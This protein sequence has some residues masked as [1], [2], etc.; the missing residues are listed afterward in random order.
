MTLNPLSPSTN[1]AARGENQSIQNPIKTQASLRTMSQK[2]ITS[3]AVATIGITVAI[4]GSL[5]ADQSF[6]K[7][8]TWSTGGGY[9]SAK[10]TAQVYDEYTSGKNH[11]ILQK[12]NA[13]ATA[14]GRSKTLAN[15]DSSL[16]VDYKTG[17]GKLTGKLKIFSKTY[18]NI[19]K[20]FKTSTTH[21]TTPIT[22]KLPIANKRFTVGVVPVRV[23][24]DVS[25]TLSSKATLA[26][27]KDN[28]SL[29]P[30]VVARVEA[31]L[32]VAA[33]ASA[34]ADAWVAAVG[35]RGT[36]SLMKSNLKAYVKL[37][38]KAISTFNRNLLL[39]YGFDWKLSTMSGTLKAF[40]KVNYFCGSKT[41]TKTIASWKGVATTIKLASGAKTVGRVFQSGQNSPVQV[42]NTNVVKSTTTSVSRLASPFSFA[43]F[44]TAR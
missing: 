44:M 20:S 3:L 40:A 18:A 21:K 23:Y 38:S 37:H 7:S 12:A 28:G 5:H 25:L 33:S 42:G 32:D 24:A 9:F 22:K 27:T 8:R 19:N 29:Y 34:G 4:S 39:D 41:W 26:I 10:A 17:H 14:F 31:P 30:T 2:T 16:H 13:T 11:T 43:R 36:L 1:N 15:V 6:N 35:V